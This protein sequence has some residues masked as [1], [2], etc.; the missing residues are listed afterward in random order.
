VKEKR[1][2]AQ[3]A[4]AHLDLCDL[5]FM[6]RT[7]SA[8]SRERQRVAGNANRYPLA[9]TSSISVAVKLNRLGLTSNFTRENG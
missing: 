7:V 2:T 4:S 8:I 9:K 1:A 6:W 3:S 5:I